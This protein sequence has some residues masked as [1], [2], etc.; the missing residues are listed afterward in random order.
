MAVYLVLFGDYMRS[1][2]S[3]GE[4]WIHVPDEMSGLWERLFP[5]LFTVFSGLGKSNFSLMT[6]DQRHKQYSKTHTLMI[7]HAQCVIT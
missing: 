6:R 5:H 2:P 1:H 4:M 7:D 3:F